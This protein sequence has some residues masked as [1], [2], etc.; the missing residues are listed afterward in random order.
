MVGGSIPTGRKKLIPALSRESKCPHEYNDHEE[1]CLEVDC[2]T[3]PG[4]QDLANNRCLAG[5]LQ[6]L[7]SEATPETVVLK[8]HTHRRYRGPS[9][10]PVFAAA[11]DLA[12]MNRALS[13]HWRP[14][15]KKCQTCRASAPCLTAKMRHQL[16]EDP[17][18]FM[19]DKSAVITKACEEAKSIECPRL[20]DCIG[21]AFKVGAER[22]ETL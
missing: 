15:D 14:S 2:D 1:L 10:A 12:A 18:G 19:C 8:R 20:R 22:R 7:S 9:L 17:T 11:S 21:V 5:I 3:C 16:L 6:I 13:M 4:A